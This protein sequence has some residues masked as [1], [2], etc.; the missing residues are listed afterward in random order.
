MALLTNIEG[1]RMEFSLLADH[2][3]DAPQIAQWYY[4]Q[5]GRFVPQMTPEKILEKVQQASVNRLKIPLMWVAHIEDVLVSVLE[6]KY[7]ENKN[8]PEYEN[9]I[10]GVF[11][12][13]L[14]RGKGIAGAL[15]KHAKEVAISMRVNPLYLQ[16]ENHHISFY[17]KNGF[18]ILHQAQHFHLTT[19][20][21]VWDAAIE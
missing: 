9:W 18:K 20:I 13:P 21:M 15:L 1:K 6:I 5:W 11:T 16:C 10:G 14:Y 19:T 2:P 3:H 17:Q 7:R 8:Y 12:H 4:E